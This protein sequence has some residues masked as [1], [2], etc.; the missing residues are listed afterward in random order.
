MFVVNL[1]YIKPLEEIGRHLEAHREFL[2]RQYA[3]GVFLASGPKNPRDGGV[4]LANGKVSRS[5]LEAIIELDPFW[6]HQLATY[7]VIEFTP[8]KFSPLL[9]DLL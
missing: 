2:D 3:D 6:R 1:T 4:I 5:E 7:D 9:G 8:A